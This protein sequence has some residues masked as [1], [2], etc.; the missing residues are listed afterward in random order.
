MQKKEWTFALDGE[1]HTVALEYSHVSANEKFWVDYVILFDED[2]WTLVSHYDFS[3]GEHHCHVTLRIV[4]FVHRITLTLDG[5]PVEMLPSQILLRSSQR[6][7]PNTLLR[8]LDKTTETASDELLRSSD[9][10][11]AE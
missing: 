6:G 4:T 1:T 10:N 7:D 9:D 5:K 11:K 8:P 2:R 3:I